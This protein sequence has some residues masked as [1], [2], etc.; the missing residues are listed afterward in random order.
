M[1][2]EDQIATLKKMRFLDN[3]DY[4]IELIEDVLNEIAQ[5][6]DNNSIIALCDIFH[7]D[8]DEPAIVG[9]LIETIFHI[10]ER[11]GLEEG[12]YELTQAIAYMKPQAKNCLKRI[13][14]SILNSEDLIN[15]YISVLKKVVP[16]KKE[17]VMNILKEISIKQ[18]VQYLDKINFIFKQIN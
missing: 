10:A 12:L 4:N 6:A 5:N 11:N 17:E 2:I 15:P 16:S 1:S 9:D 18:P 3:E 7:D 14:K 13:F 8:I